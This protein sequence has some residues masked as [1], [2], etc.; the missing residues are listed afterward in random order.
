[1]SEQFISYWDEETQ[2]WK[3]VPVDSSLKVKVARG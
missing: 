1:M 2:E 3:T